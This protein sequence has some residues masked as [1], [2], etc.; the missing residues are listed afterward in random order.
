MLLSNFVRFQRDAAPADLP[1][2]LL[3]LESP[4]PIQPGDGK[5]KIPNIADIPPKPEPKPGDADYVLKPGD[6]GYVPKKGEAGYVPQKGEEGYVLQPGDEGYVA[7]KKGEAG[8]VLQPG[9][10]GYVA[11]EPEETFWQIVEKLT[12]RKVEVTYPEGT[13]EDTPEGAALRE[14][15]V[16]T[17]AQKEFEQYLQTTDP[18]AYAYMIH[19]NAGGDDESFFND[20]RG[21]VLPEKDS[22][23]ESVDTQSMVYKYQ[24]KAQGLDDDS[25]EVLVA[26][27][28]KDNKLKE[29]AE[30][31][32]DGIDAAQKHQLAQ[33]Q[34]QQTA[35]TA[36]FDAQVADVTARVKRGIAE[37][38]GFTVPETDRP[39]F[40]KFVIDHL[41]Y[42]KATKSFYLVQPLSKESMKVQLEAM[43]LQHMKGDLSK[44]VAKKVKTE[45]SHRL[46]LQA[47]KSK[48][49][50]SKD[51]AVD[52]TNTNYIPLGDL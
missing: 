30:A 29:K 31:A 48:T 26:K 10:E 9:D 13:E 21:F 35:E 28:I 42:D 12:G 18:R 20:N 14:Q 5:D 32:Y 33:L 40:E 27:A 22:L 38:I 36:V 3:D 45:T 15:A 41:Q 17:T 50:T 16:W 49:N 19:R 4:D 11:P 44:V 46:K 23:A 25:V 24:L 1:P 51:T 37:E 2:S 43:L 6:E 47:D 7:P 39:L 34:A 8:Y 52:R